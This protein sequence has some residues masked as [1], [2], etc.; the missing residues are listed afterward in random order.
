MSLCVSL[1]RNPSECCVDTIP[2][3]ARDGRG[4]CGHWSALPVLCLG[5]ARLCLLVVLAEFPVSFFVPPLPLPALLLF[6][7]NVA[8]T[9]AGHTEAPLGTVTFPP[10]TQRSGS[11]SHRM[12]LQHVA[13]SSSALARARGAKMPGELGA[14]RVLPPLGRSHLLP[15]SKTGGGLSSQGCWPDTLEGSSATS[16]STALH[17]LSPSMPAHL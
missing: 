5:K 11:F 10:P 15:T 12:H 3:Q 6:L 17:F 13:C 7:R 14:W 1:I 16:L 2:P 9:A 4:G 8:S